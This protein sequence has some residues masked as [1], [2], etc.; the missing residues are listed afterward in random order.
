MPD[1]APVVA[2]IQARMSSSRLPGKVLM[3]IAG[4]PLLWHIVH[5]LGLCRTVDRV[6]VA[7]STEPGDDAIEEFCSGAGISC[8]RGPLENVLDRY[9]LAAEETGAAILLRVTGDSPLIDPDFVDYLVAALVRAKGDFL[10]LEPGALCAHDG[11]DIFSRRALDWLV[12]HAADDAIA[13]EHVTSYFKLH[14]EAVNTVTVP[15]FKPLA[16]AHERFSIDT[17]D[18]LALIHAL[19]ERLKALPGELRLADALTLLRE[20]PSYRRINAHV[21][22]KQIGRGEHRALICCQ[23]GSHA[24]LGHVQRSLSLAR[25]MRDKQGIG[26]VIGIHGDEAVTALI[27]AASFETVRLERVSDLAAL[28]GARNFSLAVVDVKDWLTH[29]D[30]AALAKQVPV[31]AVIDDGNERRLAATHAYYPPLPQARQLSWAGSSC[32][33]RIGWEWCVL[34]FDPARLAALEGKT[35]GHLRIAVSM[36]G[37]DPLNLSAL[38]LAAMKQIRAPFEAHFIIGPV[39][40][41][42]AGLTADIRAAGKNF[43]VLTGLTDLAATFAGVDLAVVAFGVTAFELAAL[44]VPALYL[45]ISADHARAA[46][47]FV[48]AGL[49]LALPENAS[50]GQI[51]LALAGLVENEAQRREMSLAGPKTIDGNGA[52]HIAADLTQALSRLP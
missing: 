8:V 12:S 2:I 25:A 13:R 39:F 48:S 15:G 29:G 28:A 20:E 10:V 45:A 30:V 41:D 19:Y 43:H 33:P 50:P 17:A 47:V 40:A 6:A 24:G 1:T 16:V 44:G 31:V 18:D 32:Q 5:R 35:Q 36:G 7:T 4:K 49:G 51:A 9:R 11:V 21:R 22:Q 38:A 23:G 42:P 52:S 46:S 3:P 26:V 37:A 14:P 27:R 34:G